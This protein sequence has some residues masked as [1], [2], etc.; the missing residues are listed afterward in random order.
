M[1]EDE[2]MSMTDRDLYRQGLSTTTRG[3]L[4]TLPL[5][6]LVAESAQRSLWSPQSDD[7]SIREDDWYPQKEDLSFQED[8]RFAFDLPHSEYERALMRPYAGPKNRAATTLSTQF[9][10]TD[11]PNTTSH[12]EP[13]ALHSIITYKA[14]GISDTSQ[15]SGSSSLTC[16]RGCRNNF[17]RPGDLRLHMRSHEGPFLFCS[18]PGC[19]MKFYR[20]D[21]LSYHLRT[22][23]TTLAPGPVTEYTHNTELESEVEV[24]ETDSGETHWD[25][26]PYEDLRSLSFSTSSK[27]SY[28]RSVFSDASLGSSDTDLSKHS[29]YS[30]VQIK[31][32]TKELISILQDNA[33]LTLLY[34]SG[35]AHPNIGPQV[36]ERKLR[37][38]FKEYADLLSRVA[39]GSTLKSLASQL[40]RVKA[41]AVARS[42]MQHHVAE[43]SN[44]RQILAPDLEPSSQG[45]S[46]SSSIDE[47]GFEDIV[48]FRNFLLEGEPFREL[49]VKIRSFVEFQDTKSQ[50]SEGNVMT[51]LEHAEF[52][53]SHVKTEKSGTEAPTDIHKDCHTH[54]TTEKGRD[55]RLWSGLN[56]SRRLQT[57]AECVREVGASMTIALGL[58]EPIKQSGT[59][60]IRWE[61]RCGETFFDDVREIREGGI[62]MLVEEMRRTGI[63]VAATSRSQGPTKTTFN[64]TTPS[65]AR[66]MAQKIS[67]AFRKSPA[68]QSLPFSTP[69]V[70]VSTASSPPSQ[71]TLQMMTCTKTGQYGYHLD[72]DE[73]HDVSTDQELFEFIKKQ[74]S[75]RRGHL[76]NFFSW[77]CLQEVYFRK[78]NYWGSSAEISVLGPTC[79]THH[80]CDCIPPVTMVEPEPGAEYRCT[81]AGP[82]KTC[83]PIASHL[84]M[85]WLDRPGCITQGQTWVLAQLPK[86]NCGELQAKVN[87]RTEGWGLVLKEG[88]NIRMVT[89]IVFSIVIISVP[90]VVLWSCLKHS[91]QDGFSVGQYM[92]A[93]ALALPAVLVLNHVQGG[94]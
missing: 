3:A 26:I 34:E 31:R 79:P 59:T 27:S 53:V 73:I 54:T 45:E 92:I 8:G 64:F 21:K 41:R 11:P 7:R 16:P 83:P 10:L 50:I 88:P 56:V 70:G 89:G 28:A 18:H 14:E 94:A 44:M 68:S 51:S 75:R 82:L 38:F 32:A 60:R 24:P 72:Q 1:M 9:D 36:L 47:Q 69:Q 6:K 66:N 81:P 13:G 33:V 55:G 84:L 29:G 39:V 80:T 63:K 57:M 91:I 5:S 20:R 25:H 65:F 85:H 71:Q 2:F 23:H 52:E 67:A 19:T 49:H 61:C 74:L 93:A 35:I 12:G 30:T 78:F 76:L 15:S 58:I 42:I 77:T 90:F 17:R 4:P 37:Y 22:M 62:A 43:S 87:E 40:V 48:A 46:D 86:R